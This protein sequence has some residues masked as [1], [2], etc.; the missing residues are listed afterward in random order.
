V[1]P[2]SDCLLFCCLQS[3]E[4]FY[5]RA[6]FEQRFRGFDKFVHVWPGGCRS[7]GAAWQS[8]IYSRA[9]LADTSQLRHALMADEASSE[10]GAMPFFII[11]LAMP[12]I[13]KKKKKKKKKTCLR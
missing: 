5:Y 8:A 10:V 3:K 13:Y 12:A 4:E 6:L 9:G 1:L 2:V 7:G 11:V